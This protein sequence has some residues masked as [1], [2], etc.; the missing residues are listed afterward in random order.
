M[1]MKS[2]PEGCNFNGT[3][4]DNLANIADKF[5]NRPRKRLK[6]TTPNEILNK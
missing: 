6:Y 1:T 5:N 2:A 3:T 4:D